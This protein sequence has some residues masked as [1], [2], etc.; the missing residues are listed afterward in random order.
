MKRNLSLLAAAFALLSITASA[1][2][3]LNPVIA[4]GQLIL[5]P[6][7]TDTLSV[8]GNFDSYQWFKNNQPIEGATGPFYIVE[9]YRDAASFFKVSVTKNGC[10][11]TSKRVLVDGYVFALPYVITTGEIGIYNPL[12]DVRF[13]CPGDSVIMTMGDPYNVNIQWYN[14]GKPIPGATGKTFQVTQKGSYT[15]CGSPAVC[16]SYT[17]CQNIPMNYAFDKVEPLIT[18]SNDTLFAS[19]AKTYRWYYNG[20]QI[21][22]ATKNYIV[23][24]RNGAYTVAIK[25]THDCTGMSPVYN[26]NGA[27]ALIAV[28]P[29]PVMN[30][31][32]VRVKKAGVAYI[33][34]ADL[35]GN[36]YKLIPYRND[37]ELINVSDLRMGTYVVQVLNSK[38]Q[39]IGSTK[40]FKQ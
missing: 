26:Y 3:D 12:K 35:Y 31:M 10:A 14:A 8:A 40:I 5:C 27:D 11:D 1:Q 38:Q 34:I 37:N 36:R 4:P 21:P 32:H 15:V 25:T 9:Q 22:G 39:V 29:N 13:Q 17:D 30:T 28:A 6:G 7:A 23:P 24:D 19:A 20:R 33:A 2:C 16:P 18:E